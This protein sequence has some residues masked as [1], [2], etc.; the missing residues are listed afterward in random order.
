MRDR[1]MVAEWPSFRGTQGMSLSRE[2]GG[3]D[4]QE[5]AQVSQAYIT[6]DAYI[7]HFLEKWTY[8]CG[9]T[10]NIGINNFEQMK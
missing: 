10:Q 7:S 2:P 9:I 8:C 5:C 4:S 6:L 1:P 3:L